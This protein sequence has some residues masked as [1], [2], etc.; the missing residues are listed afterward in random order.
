MV[1]AKQ[2]DGE[3]KRADDCGIAAEDADTI[4]GLVEAAMG[5]DYSALR[6]AGSQLVR[7]FSEDGQAEH[8]TRL[9][10]VLRRR[11]AP[12]RTSGHVQ[13]LPLDG[14]S[15]LP[16]VDENPL[17]ST[18]ILLEAE[19]EAIVT[20]FIEDATHAERLSRAG[21]ES[22]L[23]LILC[24]P[25]GTGKTLLAGH[26]A[27]RLNKPFQ[28][29]RLDATISSLLGDTA[30]NIRGIFDYVSEHSGFVF[31]DEIDAIAKMRDD[32]REIGELKRVVNTLI[33]GLDDLD[34]Q[35]VVIAATNHPGLLDPAVW[36]RFP[37]RIEM[38][39]PGAE[40]RSELWKLFLAIHEGSDL[41]D[42][43][44]AISDGLSPADI[45]ELAL[46]ARRA[47]VIGDA[48]VAVDDLVRC[49]LASRSGAL[50]V[51][52]GRPLIGEERRRLVGTLLPFRMTRAQMASLVG[53]SRQRVDEYVHALD[54]RVNLEG[55]KRD[56]ASARP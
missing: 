31:L 11:S 48:P 5:A 12:L 50:T 53:V 41:G 42:L 28:V 6:R 8:A 34:D 44:G 4:I 33:Q 19:T 26:I 45:R 39:L 46:G 38:K 43:L 16:L 15:R 29:A 25:P 20:R 51:P 54:E 13:E 2:L 18:P 37:Y 14:R 47:S 21:I 27:S 24:G 56:G 52:T 49:V 17:P 55:E 32:Q 10:G 3:T 30:K 40:L 9:R 22:S 1:K 7:R 36:R 23:R 35:T